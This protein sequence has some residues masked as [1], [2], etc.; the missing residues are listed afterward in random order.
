M[1]ER[2]ESRDRPGDLRMTKVSLYSY[3]IALIAVVVFLFLIL[4]EPVFIYWI[5]SFRY[6]KYIQALILFVVIFLVAQICHRIEE[7][8]GDEEEG[9]EESDEES[10]ERNEDEEKGI[11]DKTEEG[12]GG[13][14]KELL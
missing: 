5:P 12:T 6:R 8:N 9:V 1:T 3:I 11:E 4:S 2:F 14:R 13:E 7:G 10:D